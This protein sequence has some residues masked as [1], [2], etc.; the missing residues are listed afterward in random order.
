MPAPAAETHPSQD[1]PPGP[2]G[3]GWTWRF[4]LGLAGL[5]VTAIAMFYL[6]GLHHYFSWD[7]LRSHVDLLQTEAQQHLFL[8]LLLF[9][10]V[11][12][13]ATALSLPVATVLTL[14]AG[15]LFGRWLGTA[16]VSLASTLG[17]TLAFLSSRYLLRDFVQRRFGPRLETLNRGIERD[18]P[19]YLFTLRLVPAIPFFLV[20]LGLGLT[21]MRAFTFAWVSMLGMLAATFLYV[22]AGTELGRLDSPGGVLSPTVLV[23]LA[24]LGIAPLLLRKLIQWRIRPTGR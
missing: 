1:P 9:F 19:W 15:A 18:G 7:Y 4:R 6:F 23:S 14:V 3:A 8:A 5:L 22:N 16:V 21:R 2:A 12:V 17:A 11:Y 13:S 24:L 10:L 20:N